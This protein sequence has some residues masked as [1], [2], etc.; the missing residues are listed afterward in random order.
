VVILRPSALNHGGPNGDVGK[1]VSPAAGKSGEWPPFD[2]TLQACCDSDT[3]TT[4]S[5][6]RRS[7]ISLSFD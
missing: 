5:V 4:K 1:R 7:S 2:C 3:A 6:P